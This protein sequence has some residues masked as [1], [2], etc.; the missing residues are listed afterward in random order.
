MYGLRDG[1]PAYS[2]TRELLQCRRLS[3]ARSRDTSLSDKAAPH[4]ARLAIGIPVKG[5]RIDLSRMHGLDGAGG[6]R[7]GHSGSSEDANRGGASLIGQP[8]HAISSS[9]CRALASHWTFG[10][11]KRTEAENNAFVTAP[12]GSHMAYTPTLPDGHAGP[13]LEIVLS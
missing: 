11:R 2:T 13:M 9:S 3:L 4:S 1:L 12:D 7:S 10:D 8:R 6:P 5:C